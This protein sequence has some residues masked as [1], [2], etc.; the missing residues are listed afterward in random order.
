MENIRFRKIKVSNRKNLNFPQEYTPA[1]ITEK[2]AEIES[3]PEKL[4]KETINLTDKQ[5][6]TPYRPGGWTVRQ[7]IHHCAESHMNCYIRIKWAL[8]EKQSCNKSL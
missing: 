2:I 5:L 1:Y 4:K 6:D 3:F 8:T 7:V